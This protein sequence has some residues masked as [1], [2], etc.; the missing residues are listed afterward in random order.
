MTHVQL[1]KM[2]AGDV[3]A[4]VELFYQNGGLEGFSASTAAKKRPV[5]SGEDD[6]VR[7]PIKPKHDQLV[8][9]AFGGFGSSGVLYAYSSFVMLFC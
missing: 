4:A 1:R 8:P 3:S 5:P 9:E 7:A 2:A 6:E